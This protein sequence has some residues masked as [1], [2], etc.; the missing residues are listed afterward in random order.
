[1]PITCER[2]AENNDLICDIEGAVNDLMELLEE[3][4]PLHMEALKAAVAF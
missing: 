4:D 1:M 3:K 2:I